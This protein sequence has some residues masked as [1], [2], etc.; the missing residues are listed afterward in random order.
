MQTRVRLMQVIVQFC[1]QHV[2]ATQQAAATQGVQ[3]QGVSP[4]RRQIISAKSLFQGFTLV[5]WDMRRQDPGNLSG[6][7]AGWHVNRIGEAH[8]LHCKL[9]ERQANVMKS[10]HIA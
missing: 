9:P 10:V 8:R 1:R 3:E 6:A 7:L 2:E 5:S 4:R